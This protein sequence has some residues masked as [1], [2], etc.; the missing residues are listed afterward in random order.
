L[1]FSFWGICEK[2]I[3]EVK[4]KTLQALRITLNDLISE[5]NENTGQIR[6]IC[7]NTAKKARF[8]FGEDGKLFEHLLKSKEHQA[9]YESQAEE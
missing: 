6:K 2:R 5:L 9:Y 8:C 1:D 7:Q 4:P 3:A